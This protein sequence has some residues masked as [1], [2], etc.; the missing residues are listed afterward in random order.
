MLSSVWYDPQAHG[1]GR[2]ARIVNGAQ[3]HANRIYRAILGWALRWPKLTLLIALATFLGSFAL[4]EVHRL[5]VRARGRPRRAGRV[6]RDAGRLVAGIHRGQAAPGRRRGAR[7][8][9]GRLHLR[10]DQYRLCPRQEPG[11][12]VPR[13]EAAE[14]AQA[15]AQ[16]SSPSRCATAWPASPASW[17][18]STFP[19]AR[20]AACRS[21]SSSRCRGPTS[22]VLDTISQD[23]MRRAA[24][25]PRSG[26]P[27]PQ[28]QGRQAGPLGAAA[29]RRRLRPRPGLGAGGAVAQAPVRRRRDQ[30]VARARRRELHR[31]GPPAG[32]RPHAAWPTC[33]ASGSPPAPSPTACRAWSTSPRSPISSTTSAPRRSTAATST[34]RSW[35]TANVSGRS[36]GEVSQRPAEASG[37][38][39]A[40]ARLPLR[41]RRLDQG[42]RRERGL[43][44]PGAAAR[45]DPDLPDPGLAVRLLPA[46]HR[47]HDVA[48]DVAD[49]R[50]P[51]PADRRH[52]AQHLLA[53]SASSC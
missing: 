12:P 9:R 28:P 47:H 43:C 39:Q 19:A 16:R 25:N 23:V 3:E 45:G 29:P 7:V 20:A 35:I 52:H 14:G 15:L 42:H 5:R 17:R 36:A 40:A 13:A 32:R 2:F 11:E 50:V 8:S 30:P 46:A 26:R 24:G 18:R 44:R 41:V 33:S 27:R 49:R 48:A 4:A 6:D 34:A 22:A 37:R 31:H 21:S 1:T 53:P 10:H 38:D 51:G